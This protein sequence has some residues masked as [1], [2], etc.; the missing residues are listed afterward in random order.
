MKKLRVT[1]GEKVYD[2]TVEVLEDDEG[3][4]SPTPLPAPLPASLPRQV[5][6][7]VYAA[8]P[9][10]GGTSSAGGPDPDVVRSP[11]S[12]IVQKVFVHAESRVELNAPVVML[13]AM[14]M[15]T[16]IYAPRAGTIAEVFVAPG[17]AVQ[18]G[19]QLVRFHPVA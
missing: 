12:G 2:V 4:V 13:D 15:D 10:P 11:M 18:V 9:A 17:E 14:K 19:G 1:I 8:V 6:G 16:Y 3:R 7:P 5:P